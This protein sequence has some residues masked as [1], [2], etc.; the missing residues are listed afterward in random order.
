[1]G[2]T[3]FV[4]THD[5]ATAARGNRTLRLIDGRLEADERVKANGRPAP[6]LERSLS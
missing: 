6:V 5:P 2:I 1:L 3:V 4:A